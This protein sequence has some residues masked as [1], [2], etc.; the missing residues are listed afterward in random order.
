GILLDDRKLHLKCR[1]GVEKLL[2]VVLGAYSV[3][4]RDEFIEFDRAFP[5]LNPSTLRPVVAGR[6]SQPL[7]RAHGSRIGGPYVDVFVIAQ[8]D[9]QITRRFFGRLISLSE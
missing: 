4:A 7:R 2:I 6:R 9:L 8:L 3:C 1:R 5:E